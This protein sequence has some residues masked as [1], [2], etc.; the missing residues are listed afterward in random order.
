MRE[1]ELYPPVKAF[2]EAQG[3]VVKAEIGA[4]DVMAL[5][6]DDPPVIVEL[7]NRLTLALVLQGVARQAMFDH[8]YLAVPPPKG[9][10]GVRA[11]IPNQ[12]EVIGLCRRLGLGFLL[13]RGDVV[14]AVID[15]GPYRPR[16]SG[17]RA[18]RLLR[19][20]ANRVGDPNLGGSPTRVQGGSARVTAYRQDALRIARY[21]NGAG[22]SP[23]KTIRATTGITRTTRILGDNHYGWF[24]RAS[25]GVYALSPN[26]QAGL[27]TFSAALSDLPPDP[28][29]DPGPEPDSKPD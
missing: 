4:C 26:G 2:L 1:S 8:V 29:P 6:G 25:R 14:T 3:Y 24:E 7:K 28:G 21:L 17:A 16:L 20:F 18:G 19:E 27:S 12:R 22:P 15:P 23:T 9:R 13:V 5:R 11:S 10:R